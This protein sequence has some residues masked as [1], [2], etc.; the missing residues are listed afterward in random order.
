MLS[1]CKRYFCP[2]QTTFSVNIIMRDER[3]LK[4]AVYPFSDVGLRTIN[5]RLLVTDP[6]GVTAIHEHLANEIRRVVRDQLVREIESCNVAVPQL[7]RSQP[8]LS[9][10]KDLHKRPR[11]RARCN[12]S[13]RQSPWQLG[14]APPAS[15]TPY[16]RS[17]ALR[18]KNLVFSHQGTPV[19]LRV[20]RW[21]R[22]HIHSFLPNCVK[23][24]LL[25]SRRPLL[26]LDFI[27]YILVPFVSATEPA[28]VQEL[29]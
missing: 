22:S 4:V 27:L 5:R 15:P 16:H 17:V 26:P 29:L 13:L 9:W 14:H 18:S 24:S 23:P 21:C 7:L 12:R 3:R 8:S 1:G 19:C 2:F 11:F 28:S 20:H 6:Q 10:I 25:Q